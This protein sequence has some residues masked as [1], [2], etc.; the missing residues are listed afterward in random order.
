MWKQN[1]KHFFGT[2]L[3]L[4]TTDCSIS[5]FL[6]FPNCSKCYLLSLQ[7][8]STLTPNAVYSHNFLCYHLWTLEHL[9]FWFPFQTINSN[10]TLHNWTSLNWHLQNLSKV[11]IYS[12]LS[13]VPNWPLLVN[14]T[15]FSLGDCSLFWLFSYIC[16]LFFYALCSWFSLFSVSPAMAGHQVLHSAL[17]FSHH[18]FSLS[19]L[20][21]PCDLTIIQMLLAPLLTT[22]PTSISTFPNACGYRHMDVHM[23]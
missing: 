14:I 8:L 9:S 5:S 17:L 6:L 1:S 21:Y 23:T 3:P 11:F 10:Y 13:A 19:N 4:W 15:C 20:L 7:M 18:L 12:D 16:K 22:I 2:L